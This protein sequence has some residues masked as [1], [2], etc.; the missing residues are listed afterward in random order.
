[1]QVILK[2]FSV[3][4]VLGKRTK[5]AQFFDPAFCLQVGIGRLPA[6]IGPKGHPSLPLHTATW[7][8][9]GPGRQPRQPVLLYGRKGH[10]E[11]HRGRSSGRRCLQ[12]SV[13][14]M[15]NLKLRLRVICP[16]VS[17]QSILN[18]FYSSLRRTKVKG[19][20]ISLPHFLHGSDILRENVQGLNPIMEEH[21]TY[22]DVEPVRI[23]FFNSI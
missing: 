10:Q 9:G 1:M 8:L 23:Y 6:D 19:V 11:L 7:H 5:E 4:K 13:A 22:L 12:K 14:E 16:L 3:T 21:M 15:I 17:H 2:V 18:V 20:Y